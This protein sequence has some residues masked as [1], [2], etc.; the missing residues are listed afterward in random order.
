MGAD[1]MGLEG[2]VSKRRGSFYQSGRSRHWLKVKNPSF[3]RNVSAGVME[4]D[5]LPLIPARSTEVPEFIFDRLTP[6]WD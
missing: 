1:H 5:V 3:R 4:G 6:P 2:I